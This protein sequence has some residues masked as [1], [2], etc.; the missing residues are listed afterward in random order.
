MTTRVLGFSP[1]HRLALLCGFMVTT[2]ACSSQ[3]WEEYMEAGY[4]AQQSGRLQEAEEMLLVAVQYA[5]LLEHTGRERE[6]L[7][8]AERARAIRPADFVPPGRP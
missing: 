7:A 3:G 5:G 6:A 4:E 1:R 8:M 2:L